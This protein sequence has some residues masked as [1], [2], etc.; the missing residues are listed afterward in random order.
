MT[1]VDLTSNKLVKG[2]LN[3]RYPQLLII[4]VLLVGYVFAMLAGLIGTPVGSHNFSIVFVWI[5]WWAVLILVA[6]PFL[7]R[8]WCAVCPIPQPGYWIQRGAILDPPDK[9]PKWLELRWP[10]AFRNIWLQN[11]TFLLLAL[12]AVCF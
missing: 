3:S 8:G 2:L 10:K 5:A 7:G 11:I 1:R 4:F 12:L 6:V 9:K